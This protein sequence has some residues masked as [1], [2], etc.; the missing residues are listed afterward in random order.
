MVNEDEVRQVKEAF[1]ARESVSAV[2]IWSAAAEREKQLQSR[3]FMGPFA[4]V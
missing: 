1:A 2:R 4:S 3:Q